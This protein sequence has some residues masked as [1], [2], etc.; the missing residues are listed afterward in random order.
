MKVA[1]VFGSPRPKGNTAKV[2][3]W[4]EDELRAAGHAVDR[5]NIVEYDSSGCIACGSCH[6][7]TTELGCAQ[8]DDVPA[9][10]T[11]L[12]EADAILYASPLY[13]WSWSGQMKPFLDRHICLVSKAFT[14]EWSSLIEGKPIGALITAAGPREGNADLLLKQF[15][16]M[17]QY[18]KAGRT[19]ELVV[20]GCTTPDQIPPEYRTK[21]V[22][23]ARDLVR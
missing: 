5:I 18:L 10:L 1:T 11:R 23:L 7:T 15:A 8:A 9:L 2:L 13:C 4:V 3:G 17:T 19:H 14:K 16:G 21:A 12:I 22:R 6:E 20:P